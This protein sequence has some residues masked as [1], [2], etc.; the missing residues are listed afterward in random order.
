MGCFL[1]LIYGNAPELTKYRYSL[2]DSMAVEIKRN[3]KFS[4][5]AFT[6]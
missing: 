5:T 4:H 3:G 2:E 6:T 1:V